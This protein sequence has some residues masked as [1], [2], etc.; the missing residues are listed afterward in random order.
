MTTLWCLVVNDGSILPIEIDKANHV[1]TL[2]QL[3]REHQKYKFHQDRLD[4]FVAKKSDGTWLQWRSYDVQALRTDEKTDVVQELLQ[5]RRMGSFYRIDDSSFGFPDVVDDGDIHI[6]AV[7]PPDEWREVRPSNKAKSTLWI[8]TEVFIMPPS[9][10]VD[11]NSVTQGTVQSTSELS[12]ALRRYGDF[13]P[14]LF[15]RQEM[16]MAWSILHDNYFFGYIPSN[17]TTVLVGSPG[18]GKS[19]LL[20][21]FCCYLAVHRK[22]HIFLARNLMGKGGASPDVVLWFRGARVTGYP[23]CFPEEVASLRKSFL[24]ERRGNNILVV[25]DG[26]LQA[27]FNDGPLRILG[28]GHLLSSSLKF[29]WGVPDDRQLVALPGWSQESLKDMATALNTSMSDFHERYAYSGG[30][31]RL[32]NRDLGD[33]KM[34][35][36]FQSVTADTPVAQAEC[37]TI[38]FLH[39]LFISNIDSVENYVTADNYMTPKN[40]L[41]PMWIC[42]G[43]LHESVFEAMVHK[44]AH[45]G[46][47]Q[48]S[49]TVNHLFGSEV[50]TVPTT[51]PVTTGHMT[52]DDSLKFDA[53]ESMYWYP[54]YLPFPVV[55]SVLVND[56]VIYY[57]KMTLD[58]NRDLDW[59][60]MQDIHYAVSDNPNLQYHDFKYV[61]VA[62]ATS[63]SKDIVGQE[64]GVDGVPMCHGHG[65]KFAGMEELMS[66]VAKL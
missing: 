26:Y 52:W 45:I 9:A 53:T 65:V 35:V 49:I 1:Q 5:N 2:K 12:Q 3:V 16:K 48:L 54:T 15:V 38:D 55:D 30:N 61:V 37:H 8:E 34:R 11:L 46:L 23:D 50:V 64:C 42:N 47:L 40:Y 13:P 4:L 33:L 57:L 20:V 10:V 56:G 14:S 36:Q 51:L 41:N 22:F 6:L 17:N 63:P 19:A 62:P 60:K 44:L 27:T 31:A 29:I 59:A 28:G 7:V 32:F 58:E 25:G 66:F 24:A 39:S 21:L 43:S 18:V